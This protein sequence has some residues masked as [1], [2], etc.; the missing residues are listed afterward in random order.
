[1]TSLRLGTRGSRLART[2]SEWVADRIRAADPSLTVEL[3]EIRTSGDRIVDVPLGPHLGQAFFTREIEVALLEGHVD[4]AVHSCKDLATVNPAGLRIAALP[5]REDPLDVLVSSAGALDDLPNGARVGTSSPR[6]KG[7][8]AAARPDLRVVDQRGNVPTRVRAVEEGTLDAVV[9][10]AAGLRR[11]GLEGVIAETL[12]PSVMLPAA[13]QGALAVQVRDDAPAVGDLV[14]TLDDASTRA[15]VTAERA[16]LRTLEAGCQAPVGALAEMVG[17][18]IRLDAAIVT[19]DGI[20]RVAERGAHPDAER[21][22]AA[23]AAALL[24]RL[25]LR[26]LRQADWAGAAPM[27]LAGPPGGRS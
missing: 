23:A 5:Q 11:L 27:R 6:R 18:E 16:C 1:V 2:Q 4:L 24:D 17:G 26:S 14:R 25:G 13:S 9:L 8:L 10:A 20:V 3:V 21:V 12:P 7:F 19:P 22:G 15:C